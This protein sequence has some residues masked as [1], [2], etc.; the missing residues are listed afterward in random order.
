M[1]FPLKYSRF[2]VPHFVF[3]GHG[4]TSSRGG[5]GLQLHQL[6]ARQ[7]KGSIAVLK[8]SRNGWV[9]EVPGRS[10]LSEFSLY[11]VSF[12]VLCLYAPNLN[13][14]R[15]NFFNRISDALDPSIPT[16]VRRL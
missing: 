6:R 1:I 11:D 5:Q 2:W 16:V 8:G 14:A 7:Q 15:D 9:G 4:K 13:P 12:R 3:L 10:L